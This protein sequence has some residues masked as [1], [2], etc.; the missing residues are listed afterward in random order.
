MAEDKHLQIIR[1]SDIAKITGVTPSY[2][3]KVISGEITGDKADM[4]LFFLNGG[5]D[6]I[7]K[8]LL[9]DQAFIDMCNVALAKAKSDEKGCAVR[10]KAVKCIEWAEFLKRSLI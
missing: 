6:S 9:C 7:I 10:R 8:E 3:S 2:V 1:K 4:I 5:Y